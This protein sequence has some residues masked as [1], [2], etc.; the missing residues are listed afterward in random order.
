MKQ[1]RLIIRQ[2]DGKYESAIQHY[3]LGWMDMYSAKGNTPTEARRN[4]IKEIETEIALLYEDFD[5]ATYGVVE[6]ER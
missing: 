5:Y 6:S 4:L 1:P 3:C 2:K